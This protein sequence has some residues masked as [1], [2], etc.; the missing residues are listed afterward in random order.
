MVGSLYR[1]TPPFPRSEPERI[2][3]AMAQV[4][5]AAAVII[6]VFFDLR[7]RRIPNWLTMPALGAGLILQTIYAGPMGL[8]LALGGAAAGAA[9]L[10]LP[11]AAGW[12]G[13]GDLKLLAAIGALMGAPFAFWTV[14]F[15]SAA[16]GLLTLGWLAL[17]GNLFGSLKYIFTVWRRNTDVK[18]AA[19]ATSLSFGPALA[20]GV[21]AARFLA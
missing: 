12:V 14:L 21:I 17:T 11:F 9:F 5:L 8:L 6:G 3:Q 1:A 19:L 20:L 4:V 10:A 16:G 13:G 2:Y 7:E 15:A 18:P